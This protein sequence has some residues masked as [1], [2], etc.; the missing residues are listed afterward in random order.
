MRGPD[1]DP[2]QGIGAGVGEAEGLEIVVVGEVNKGDDSF[3]VVAFRPPDFAAIDDCP[4]PLPGLRRD[5]ADVVSFQS[6]PT[7]TSFQIERQQ[8]RSCRGQDFRH[9][10][11]LNRP[12]RARR[13]ESGSFGIK[14]DQDTARA[15]I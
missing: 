7:L 4:Q 1:E 2:A 10:S 3:P 11:I 6:R 8:G 9:Y 15:H 14:L 12:P 13:S 5:R